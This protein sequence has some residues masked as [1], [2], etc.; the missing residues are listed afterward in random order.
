MGAIIAIAA[1]AV[2]V[3]ARSFAAIAEWAA[4]ARSMFDRTNPSA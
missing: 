3:G 1:A 2:L 4:Q